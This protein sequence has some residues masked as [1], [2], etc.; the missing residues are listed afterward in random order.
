MPSLTHG[1]K[2]HNILH[3]MIESGFDSNVLK[4]GLKPFID[5]LA[6]DF[7]ATDRQTLVQF[8]S[9]NDDS[10]FSFK[11]DV[12]WQALACALS[13]SDGD[14]GAQGASFDA[15][16]SSAAAEDVDVGDQ[17]RGGDHA[18][19]SDAI[20]RLTFE[21][22]R[23]KIVLS[24]VN[25]SM[26][27]KICN[28]LLKDYA[29]CD[30][31]YPRDEGYQDRSNLRILTAPTQNGKT[32]EMLALAW[33]AF[34]KHGQSTYLFLRPDATAYSE[35]NDSVHQFNAKIEKF[36]K[37]NRGGIGFDQVGLT[38]SSYGLHP[39]TLQ[40]KRRLEPAD[41]REPYPDNHCKA[42]IR[43]RLLQARNVENAQCL[44]E[45]LALMV[46]GVGVSRDGKRMNVVVMVD[47]SQNS[48]QTAFLNKHAL[49]RALFRPGQG[50]N[51]RGSARKFLQMMEMDEEL[52]E[53][54]QGS[55]RDIA[56]LYVEVTATPEPTFMLETESTAQILRCKIDADYFGYWSE[57]PYNR[58]IQCTSFED[59]V[60]LKDL[61]G[62]D[63]KQLAGTACVK[64]FHSTD[65]YQ[66]NYQHIIV[67][68]R[69][70]CNQD[71]SD[72][73]DF[74][75]NGN[76]TGMGTL[77]DGFGKTQNPARCA[78]SCSGDLRL[79]AEARCFR[80]LH[81]HEQVCS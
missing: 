80:Y 8:G 6:Q 10:S 52:A 74:I 55:L 81:L 11:E 43:C 23:D 64:A 38:P 42:L 1:L 12:D 48:R 9:F 30:C 35:L 37:D 36:V 7:S 39:V 18:Y 26:V 58:S 20:E 33:V 29:C 69:L 28:E 63:D 59:H 22:A 66:N 50:R 57:L 17:V 73:A 65:N 44:P 32:Q 31:I 78:S 70:K 5:N 14:G 67:Y 51:I 54:L 79:R 75:T 2:L 56:S 3:P 77:A 72:M 76:T 71:M 49:E 16:S 21:Q 34:F 47:E 61:E 45:E 62:Q 41:V 13:A 46:E 68:H 25:R 15:D 19:G 60:D 24:H 27:E 4:Q 53:N 40:T